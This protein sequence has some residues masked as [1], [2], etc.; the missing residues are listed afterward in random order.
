[1]TPMRRTVL[2]MDG[3]QRAALA[4]V[5]SLGR[6][7][8]T[9][10]V[11]S[12]ARAPLAGGSKYATATFQV[13]DGLQ[14]PEQ[15]AREIQTLIKAH[16][17]DTLIPVTEASLLALLP[18]RASMPGVLLP[19]PELDTFSR[20]CDKAA[21][22]AQAQREGIAVPA[23][24]TLESPADVAALDLQH[25]PFPMVVKPAR[26][27]GGNEGDR[28]KFVVQYADTPEELR[29]LLTEADPRAYPLLLQQRIVGP[30]IGIFVLVWNDHVLARFAHRRLR[31]HPPA[32]GVSVYSA[33][34]PMDETLLERA[35]R[36][37]RAF[38]WSGVAMVECKIDAATGTPYLMEINGRFWGS[39]QLAI[40]SGVDF[41]TL[42]L[43][44]AAGESVPPVTTYRVGV[45]NR[46]IWGEVNHLVTRL[47][48]SDHE[49][50][51]PP[52]SPSRG[53]MLRNFF[54]WSPRDR[55][56]T[57]QFGDL[58]PFW[59]ETKQWFSSL[60]HR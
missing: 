24:Q 42:L 41:P 39:L 56:E 22:L 14:H 51:L 12:S 57:P 60:R 8:H 38:H 54:S 27:V 5:R 2:V 44:A 59:R 40:S 36:L 9:V 32:G 31:E 11:A 3:E 45:R 20:V 25:L 19:F 6:A 1:M 48:H 29:T 15:L 7:G 46:W 30:G 55:Y 58:R 4:I 34:V 21:V 18:H 23:Q 53:A 37:L 43:R 47:R 17:V 10:Y 26:S 16:A 33:S 13:S 52:E 50:A 28:A 35:V 49:L